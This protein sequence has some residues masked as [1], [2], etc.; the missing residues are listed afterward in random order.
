MNVIE[1]YQEIVSKALE[2]YQFNNAEPKELY[3]PCD[4]ILSIGGKRLRPVIVMLGSYIFDG[5]VEDVIKPALAIEFFHNF[6]LMHDDIMDEAPLRRGMQTVH[7]K[8]NINT[9]ILSGDAMLIQAYRMFEDLPAEKFKAVTQLFSKTAV[10]LC[11]GQQYDMNFETQKEVSY[12]EYIK[13]ISL[14]TGVM[15]GASLQ[16]GGMIAGGNVE[17]CQNLYDFGLHLGIA[18]QLKDDYLDVF[19]QKDFGKIHAGDIIENKK[20]IL[21][22]KALELAEKSDADEL[23]F[24]Y[25]MKTDNI[26]KV[27][28]VERIYKASKID[29]EVMNLIGEY[30][31][32]AMS[33]LNK[34]NV[35]EEKKNSLKALAAS[36]IDRQI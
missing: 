13:M 3:E 10:E 32:K 1:E 35:S 21:Y 17:D 27:Y 11:E 15:M 22:I 18:F 12:D 19:G 24:W 36:L 30:T 29:H 2:N 16:I 6:S 14:K 34:I 4:Y 5:N 26:D 28:A 31:D 20:T 33:F 7:L 23:K 25:G 9:G 8:Y